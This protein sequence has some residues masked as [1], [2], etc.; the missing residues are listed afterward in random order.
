M[1]SD[2]YVKERVKD[3][4]QLKTGKDGRANYILLGSKEEK[5]CFEKKL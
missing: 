4:K 5:M 1:T 3:R 2:N